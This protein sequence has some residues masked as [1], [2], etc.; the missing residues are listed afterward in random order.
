M[1]TI[2]D[3]GALRLYTE[4]GKL[5]LQKGHKSVIVKKILQLLEMLE[6]MGLNN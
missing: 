5:L 6:P 4:G 2:L 1:V 3:S